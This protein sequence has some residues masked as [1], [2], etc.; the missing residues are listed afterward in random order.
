MKILS[1]N[2]DLYEYLLFLASALKQ[3]KSVALSEAVG[4]AIGNAASFSTEFLGES[5]IALKQ[6]LDQENGVLTDQERTDLQDA[7]KQLDKIFDER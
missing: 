4:L 5:R 1:S 2:E 3:R 6:V 7:W